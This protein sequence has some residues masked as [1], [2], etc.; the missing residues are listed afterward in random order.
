MLIV[1]SPDRKNDDITYVNEIMY[2]LAENIIVIYS[3]CEYDSVAITMGK[4]YGCNIFSYIHTFKFATLLLKS[5][6]MDYCIAIPSKGRDD[7]IT[8]DI[9]RRF[10]I[11]ENLFVR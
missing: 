5:V 1:N 8:E 10:P 3:F 7:I 6:D 4:R 11:K 2:G 9:I